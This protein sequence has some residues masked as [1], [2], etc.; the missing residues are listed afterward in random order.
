MA[1]HSLI[2]PKFTL[3]LQL[4]AIYPLMFA[5]LTLHE[6]GHYLADIAYGIYPQIN[7]N[8]AS[9]SGYVNTPTASPSLQFGISGFAGILGM[10]AISPALVLTYG[11][12]SIPIIACDTAYAIQEFIRC[13]TGSTVYSW[14]Q[15]A[16]LAL[17]LVAMLVLSFKQM[18]KLVEK[19]LGDVPKRGASEDKGLLFRRRKRNRDLVAVLY[20]GMLSIL[21]NKDL[22]DAGQVF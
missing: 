13:A 6:L 10:I 3:A 18:L 14:I 9:L 11:K 21:F 7:Y 16:G 2:K 17:G 5:R 22:T 19:T 4:G 8:F 20:S 15:Y 12:L 1:V